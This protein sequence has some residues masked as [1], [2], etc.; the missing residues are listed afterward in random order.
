MKSIFLANDYRKYLKLWVESQIES[1]GLLTRISRA[2]GCQ[3]SYLT[4]VLADEVHFTP[5]QAYQLT[6][7]LKLTNAETQ[8]FLKLVDFDRAG[9]PALRARLKTELDLMRAEQENLAKRYAGSELNDLEKVMTYYSAWYWSAIHILTDIPEYQNPERIA[10]RLK[11]EEKF[12]RECLATLEKFDLVKRINDQ[13]WQISSTPMHL[14]KNSP[15]ISKLHYNW[16]MQALH[17]SEKNSTDSLHFSIVQT[18]SHHDVPVIKQLILEALDK[19]RAVAG[20]SAAEELICFNCD[21]FR[22]S[23][24]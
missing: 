15:M 21:F 19:Y 3:N 11:L 12:V 17:D 1:R 20:P 9:T 2:I 8:F 6:L 5:D 13:K 10:G 14:P 7:F 4:R 23:A 16:R 22:V 18:V 24:N